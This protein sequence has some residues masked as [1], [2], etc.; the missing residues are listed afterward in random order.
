MKKKQ[1]GGNNDPK[2]T[3]SVLVKGGTNQES[4]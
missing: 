3:G 2:L 1:N 4:Q